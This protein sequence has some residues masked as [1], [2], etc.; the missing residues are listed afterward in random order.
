MKSAQV[1]SEMIYHD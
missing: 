1:V